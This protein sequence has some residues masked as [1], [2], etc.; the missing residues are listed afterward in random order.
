M[1]SSFTT[2]LHGRQ[3]VALA[4]TV[5]LTLA[6]SA[7]ATIAATVSGSRIGAWCRDVLSSGVFG[8][9]FRAIPL[10][11]AAVS[12]ASVAL[13]IAREVSAV[14]R[15]RR[16]LAARAMPLP[17]RVLA[18]LAAVGATDADVLAIRDAR[19]FAYAFGFLRTRIVVSSG[20][21]SSLTREELKTVLRHELRHAAD[22]HPLRA[23]LWELACRAFFFIPTLRDVSDHLALA[24]ELSADRAALQGR[25]GRKTLASALLKTAS[26]DAWRPVS[27]AAFGHLRG[28]IES[29]AG[30]G[31][32]AISFGLRRA[33]LSALAA[34]TLAA[35]SALPA[36]AEA[37]DPTDGACR[38]AIAQTVR[39][40]A[41]PMSAAFPPGPSSTA[42]SMQ[43][44]EIAP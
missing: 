31:G 4:G 23:F 5:A 3:T 27:L 9:G 25:G 14:S 34:I 11:L 2:R 6:V 24:R 18:A 44:V 42:G 7:G 10:A 15:L 22:R 13:A 43:S 19:A 21:L 12:A 16:E 40:I 26:H 32:A 8:S 1:R 20:L 41:G 38:V 28:R 30:T 36:R 39:L 37:R 35:V 29:L 17:G 33:A